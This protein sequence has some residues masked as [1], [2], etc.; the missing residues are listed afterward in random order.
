MSVSQMKEELHQRLWTAQERWFDV[1]ADGQTKRNLKVEGLKEEGD[2]FA[3]TRTL[4]FTGTTRVSYERE[5]KHFVEYSHEVRGKTR[6]DEIDSKDFRS[7]IDHLLQRGL[8]AKE[9][10][11][12]KSA[13]SKFGALYGKSESF[14]RISRKVGKR[15]RDLV[16]T[17]QLA[18]PAR[19][20]VTP[21]V[22]EAVIR[23]LEQL[24]SE[25]AA[26]RAYALAARLQQEASLRA[27][28]ATER[29]GQASLLGLSAE[30][31]II[32]I[33]GKG[34]RI[35]TAEI[36]LDLYERI[37]EHFKR[38]TRMDLADLRS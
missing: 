27:I 12:V 38:S 34:G 31:G 35:R 3:K 16:R 22:R 37:E 32:S 9:V 4:I 21:A 6:N 24:D 18:A 14:E 28:E 13:I 29:F 15:I 10:N 33:L 19:P 17:G 30:K 26:P 2:L 8:S 36:S 7:Y 5:L 25:C 1:K 11:K 20:H 23:R